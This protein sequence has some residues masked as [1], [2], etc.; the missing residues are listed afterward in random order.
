VAVFTVDYPVVM[1]GPVA[2]FFFWKHHRV[3][4]SL[5]LISMLL[6]NSSKGIFALKL[7]LYMRPIL[8]NCTLTNICRYHDEEYANLL[9]TMWLIAITFLIVRSQIAN[10]LTKWYHFV[11]RYHDEEHA[12]LLNTMWLIAIT[13]LI[14]RSQ[15]GIT[16]ICRCHDEEHANLLNAIWWIAV[17]FL[18]VR[19]QIFISLCEGTMTRSMLIC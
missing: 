4:D 1:Q 12:N 3:L 18:S 2:L 11:C 19:S 15:I 14:V 6:F 7:K 9:N 10:S 13:F 8:R 16:N 17:T 5:H